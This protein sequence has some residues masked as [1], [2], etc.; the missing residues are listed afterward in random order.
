MKFLTEEL[1][2]IELQ[3][4]QGRREYL[5]GAATCLRQQIFL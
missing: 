3:S 1:T 2:L 5:E 4:I